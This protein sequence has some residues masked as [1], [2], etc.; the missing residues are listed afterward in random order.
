MAEIKPPGFWESL[1]A[2]LGRPGQVPGFNVMTPFYGLTREGKAAGSARIAEQTADRD[3]AS[4]QSATIP[5]Q[6]QAVNA[7][8][9]LAAGQA[10]NAIAQLP[11]Q[12][13]IESAKGA[14]SLADLRELIRLVTDD[15]N[16]NPSA[17]SIARIMLD[18]TDGKL[19]NESK[20]FGLDQAKQTSTDVQGITGTTPAGAREL[21]AWKQGQSATAGQDAQTAGIEL[22]N[23]AAQNDM[24]VNAGGYMT[25]QGA[26][27]AAIPANVR[28]GQQQID[29]QN[30]IRQGELGVNAAAIGGPG[31]TP[32]QLEIMRAAGIKIPK[33]EADPRVAIAQ[34]A[35]EANLRAGIGVDRPVAPQQRPQA[36][37]P[38]TQP[39]AQAQP[40]QSGYSPDDMQALV[41]QYLGGGN[42]R[43]GL[44]FSSGIPK[45]T[46]ED[47]TRKNPTGDLQWLEQ[48]M[49][50]G[51][52]GTN[53]LKK[54]REMIK[55]LKAK[56]GK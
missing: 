3:R 27:A 44:D 26:Q 13:A 17:T 56:G 6:T 35:H 38:V 46:Y 30:A 10:D 5:G 19:N 33:P 20:Q 15:P 18:L 25:P 51:R 55:Q 47:P 43:P 48:Q 12:R 7:Q 42:P 9:Q 40:T 49:S 34:R 50:A 8:S 31:A 14:A 1:A 28:Q 2:N 54:V 53:D 21:M 16:K 24:A 4:M 11:Q 39:Q 45:F 22:G 29:Q 52:L 36:S 41:R 32:Q 37:V 23:R